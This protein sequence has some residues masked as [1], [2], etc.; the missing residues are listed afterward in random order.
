MEVEDAQVRVQD[1]A[2][3]LQQEILPK[4]QPD[5][6]TDSHVQEFRIPY[7]TIPQPLGGLGPRRTLPAAYLVENSGQERYRQEGTQ[8][9]RVSLPAECISKRETL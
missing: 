7:S 9:S 8:E 5:W 3:L 6:R 1:P 4:G 2:Q